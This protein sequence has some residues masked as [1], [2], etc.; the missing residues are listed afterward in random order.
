M[1]VNWLCDAGVCTVFWKNIPSLIE[2]GVIPGFENMSGIVS[3]LKVP[4]LAKLVI[5]CMNGSTCT[6]FAMPSFV[7]AWFSYSLLV[8]DHFYTDL[9]LPLYDRCRFFLVFDFPLAVVLIEFDILCE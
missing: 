7:P 1:K 4:A 6:V 5:L 2:D 3:I 9:L 8:V